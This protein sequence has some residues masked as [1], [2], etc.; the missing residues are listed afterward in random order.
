MNREENADYYEGAFAAHMA[1]YIRY[2]RAQG[3]KYETVPG[4]LRRLSRFLS[5]NTSDESC[6]RP[7]AKLSN[8]LR[9]T[10]TYNEIE[11]QPEALASVT[12]AF[13]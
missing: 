9:I 3:L 2:K 10:D 11:A 6:I 1:N 5:S 7:L 13:G 8:K 4:C 12:V